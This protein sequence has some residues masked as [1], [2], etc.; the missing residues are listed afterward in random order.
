MQVAAMP[1]TSA[2]PPH[3]SQYLAA[4]LLALAAVFALAACSSTEEIATEAPQITAPRAALPHSAPPQL[5][6]MPDSQ[7]AY[8]YY[9]KTL[10]RDPTDGAA[11]AS[12]AEIL[13]KRGDIVGAET[14]INEALAIDPHNVDWLRTK[15][16][17]QIRQ[18]HFEDARAIYAQAVEYAP[19]DVRALNGLGVSLD[20]LKRH[21]AAQLAYRRALE[22]EPA[23]YMSLSNLGHSLVLTGDYANAIKALEPHSLRKDAPAMLRQNL[24]EAYGLSGMTVDAERI[25]KVDMPREQ[26]AKALATYKQRRTALKLSPNIY[27]DLGRSP[28]MAMAEARREEIM[29]KNAPAT[30]GIPLTITPEINAIGSTPSFV[31]TGTGFASLPKAK[32]YCD[33]MR[34]IGATCVIHAGKQK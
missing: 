17:L 23:N 32:A 22:T 5:A 18:G 25:L 1:R 34:A 12:L 11:R 28:T 33:G 7:A 26:I 19:N 8:E 16:K 15:G 6:T 10:E 14:Q 29:A 30:A 9:L 27:I 13:E 20:H 3:P 31:L 21:N 24:A 2:H 4:S